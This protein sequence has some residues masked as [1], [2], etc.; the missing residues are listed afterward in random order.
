MEAMGGEVKLE[1]EWQRWQ[2]GLD[3]ALAGVG[4]GR[5]CMPCRGQGQVLERDL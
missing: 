1:G 4:C 2:A 3:R 5:D